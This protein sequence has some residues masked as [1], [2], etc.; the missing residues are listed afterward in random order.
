VTEPAGPSPIIAGSAARSGVAR[1]VTEVLAPVNLAVGLLLVVGWHSAPSLAG[2]GW[3]L[4]A[5]MFCG[6]IPTAIIVHGARRHRWTDRHVP[7]RRQRP[8]AL[9]AAAVSVV[10]GLAVLV[11]LGA[12]RQLVA[13][14]AA[15]LAGLAA[16]LT[17]TV[18]WKLSVHTAVAGGTVAVLALSFGPALLLTA[19]LVGLVAW[20]RVRL[21]DHTPAQS[22]AGVALG[23]LVA[24]AV[25]G[26]LR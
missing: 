8:A 26:A 14:V 5:A 22:A 13:L 9:A 18:W 4:L 6:L 20:S 19:P 7:E 25:I 12:P 2:L 15:M 16:T 23:T 11:A 10:A 1:F 21:G 17:V 24:T 3:G